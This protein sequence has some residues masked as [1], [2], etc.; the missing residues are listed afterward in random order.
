[1][2][3]K[4]SYLNHFMF[5]ILV[6]YL[7]VFVLINLVFVP[8]FFI[9]DMEG[10][11]GAVALTCIINNHNHYLIFSIL[12]SKKKNYKRTY[13]YMLLFS[14]YWYTYPRNLESI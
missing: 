12:N 1:M 10:F 11:M 5:S 6:I 13:F 14:I 7:Y 3:M 4:T 9:I 8:R 2:T